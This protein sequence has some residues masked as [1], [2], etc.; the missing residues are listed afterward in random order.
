MHIRYVS[1]LELDDNQIKLTNYYKLMHK[2][3]QFKYVHKGFLPTVL[4]SRKTKHQFTN[5]TNN[6]QKIKCKA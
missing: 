5:H 6:S 2:T 3:I 1:T 4:S